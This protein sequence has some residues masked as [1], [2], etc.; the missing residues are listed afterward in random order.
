MRA[1][2]RAHHAHAGAP[3][4]QVLLLLPLRSAI[5]GL[6]TEHRAVSTATELRAAIA[7]VTS[8]APVE[9]ALAE[10]VYP[11][12]AA[13]LVHGTRVTLRGEGAG[14]TLD[15]QGVTRLFDVAHGAQLGLEHVHLTRGGD[16]ESGA[17]IQVRRGARVDVRDANIS[18]SHVLEGASARGGAIAAWEPPGLV[19]LYRL[20]GGAAVYSVAHSKSRMAA[21]MSDG[22]I[23]VWD[24]GARFSASRLP[25]PR[26]ASPLCRHAGARRGGAERS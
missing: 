9:I 16:V 25:A 3:P 7:N 22:T 23:K 20:D 19:E 15:G 10:G 24:S 21:G 26:D 2:S 8:F 12:Y 5:A 1:P 18:D 6:A 11:L 17:A 14:A 4:L 13:L